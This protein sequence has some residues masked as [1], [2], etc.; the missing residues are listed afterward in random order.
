MARSQRTRLSPAFAAKTTA[1]GARLGNAARRTIGGAH[2]IGPSATIAFGATVGGLIAYDA[3][4]NY[5]AKNKNTQKSTTKAHKGQAGRTGSTG[6]LSAAQRQ[7]SARKAA[8]TRAR[9]GRG[10]RT[11]RDSH[12]RYAGSY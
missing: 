7:A 4:K 12:G 11:K 3:L 6:N 9:S 5:T 1:Y 2:G 10:N 8:A